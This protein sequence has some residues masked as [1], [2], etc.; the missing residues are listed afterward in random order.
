MSL[1]YCTALL[2][3]LESIAGQNYPGMKVTVPGFLNML[4]TQPNRPTVLQDAYRN[5]HRRD[6]TVKY[7]VRTT[8]GQVSTT[9]TCAIDLVPAYKETS[10][11]VDNI[12]QIGIWQSDDTIRQYCEDASRSVMIGQ[13]ATAMMA[14]HLDSILH[15]LNG[16][17]QKMETVLTTDMNTQWGKHAATGT[18]TAVAVNIEQDSTLNDLSTGITRLLGDAAENEFCGNPIFV[19]QLNGLMH[20]YFLQS[21]ARA[22][23]ATGTAFDA[24]RMM[25][26][27]NF[28]FFPSAKTATTWGSNYVGMFAPGSVHLLERLDNV[29]SF[30]GEKGGSTFATFYDPRV[31]CWTP[32][33][34]GNMAFD[35][36]MKY[37]DCPE[38]NAD[39]LSSG[40]INVSNATGR[41]WAM[42]IK[43]RYDLFVTPSDSFDGADR[44]KGSNGSLLYSLT[45]S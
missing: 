35:I 4:I 33:G 25:D 34:L 31:Q 21:G 30:A 16:L 18:A 40:Y 32:N 36:Q 8:E 10:V 17:Y 26:M 37:I 1:G 19:G 29:G 9:D 45:N 5:G 7:K 39:M 13:P 2:N 11:S 42:F 23:Q 3:H 28:S 41:G 14:E 43:K 22:L 6:Q 15:A 27:A 38:S 12:A 24:Q 20:R 44:L